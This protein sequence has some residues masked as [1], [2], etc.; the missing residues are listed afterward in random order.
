VEKL[1]FAGDE[2]VAVAVDCLRHGMRNRV[3]RRRPCEV[4]TNC[5]Q[6]M[7]GRPAMSEKV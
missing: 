1:R 3:E 7:V 5:F 6:D 4:T 2:D